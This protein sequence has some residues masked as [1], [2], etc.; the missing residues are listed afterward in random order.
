[1][2][3]AALPDVLNVLVISRADPATIE[4]IK[5]IAPG[6]LN[7]LHVWDDFQPELA[8]DWPPSQMARR[9]G[10]G[11]GPTRSRDELEEVIRE[12]HVVLLSVPYPRKVRSR[13][14]NLIW[15]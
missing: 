2:T 13:M 1:M 5:A 9:G 4:R 8:E 6:R 11:P 12:A 14:P 3:A 15:A 10:G 7:V